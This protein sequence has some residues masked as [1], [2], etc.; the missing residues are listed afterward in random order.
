[1]RR[2]DRPTPLLGGLSPRRFLARHWQKRPLLVRGA[3]DRLTGLLTP[4]EL[5]ALACRDEVESRVV[6][7]RG[8]RWEVHHGPF[9]PRFFRRLPA[10]NWTLLVQD[11]NHFVAE[12]RAL[13]QCF[14][15]IPYA[16]LDDLMVSYARPGGGVGP[17]FDSYDVFL[18]Q[19][20]G[21]RSWRISS[22]RDLALL[23]DAPLKLLADF[24]PEQEWV[25]GPGDMLYLPPECAHDGV[26]A[27]ECMT[28]SIGF[29]A[30]A[31]QEL[32]VQFLVHLQDRLDLHGSYADSGLEPTAR[33]ARLGSDLVHATRERLD[34]IRWSQAEVVRFLGCYLTE[35]KPHVVF[36]PPGRALSLH[37]FTRR[38]LQ[39]GVALALKS[40]MLYDGAEMFI[41]G[42][43]LRIDPGGR[44]SRA[45]RTRLRE[46]AD[47][48][49]LQPC[50]EDPA[51]L[52]EQLHAWYR[53]GYLS[54][55][56]AGPTA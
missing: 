25:L 14:D 52:F 42:E 24:H 32:G 45:V 51:A 49:R 35:P 16:R 53:A 20:S 9:E 30:P 5:I 7:R 33:P 19:G 4:S 11:V 36:E 2:H 31:W 23:A 54:L 43:H 41:N 38:A 34:R 21:H 37:A 56:G 29:R 12:G 18:L 46:L 3:G 8:R 26:A 17:H 47:T 13:L 55:G 27:D 10:R 15:F 39:T 1:M 28:Y 22:Q 40:Q 48:R 44:L 50:R 6:I